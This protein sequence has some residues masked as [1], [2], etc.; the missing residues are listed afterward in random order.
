[1]ATVED[2]PGTTTLPLDASRILRNL[3]DEDFD[4]VYVIGIKNGARSFYL[5]DPDI[6]Y[7]HLMLACMLRQLE[8]QV[9]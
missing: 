9:S 3:A 2:F 8:D 1:M 4:S 5:S 6:G 7:A